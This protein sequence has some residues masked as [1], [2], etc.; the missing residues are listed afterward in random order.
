M[1][2]AGKIAALFAALLA[3][4][5]YRQFHNLTKPIA[6]PTL[7]SNAYWGR[8]ADAATTAHGDTDLQPQ[9]IYYAPEVIAELWRRLNASD[10]LHYSL[11][12]TNNEYGINVHTFQSYVEYWRFVYMA[13]W[14][15]RLALINSVPH[16][17]TR[18]QG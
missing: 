13:K 15:K 17:Q 1:A 7:D 6:K 2:T 14:P 5:A 3:V 4:L 16:Y 9:Q 8:S 11:E 18:I 10:W 12:D